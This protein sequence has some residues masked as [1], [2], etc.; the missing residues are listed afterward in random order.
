MKDINGHI[1]LRTIFGIMHFDNVKSVLLSE[2]VNG[3]TA[4]GD[5]GENKKEKIDVLVQMGFDKN[6]VDVQIIERNPIG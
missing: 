2:D 4:L 6:D 1:V 3:Y 5:P